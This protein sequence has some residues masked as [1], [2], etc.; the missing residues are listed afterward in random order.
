MQLFSQILIHWVVIYLVD[1]AIQLLNNQGLV[2][3]VIHLLN[4]WA[5]VE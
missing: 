4:N 2:D 3:G 1:S 5:P